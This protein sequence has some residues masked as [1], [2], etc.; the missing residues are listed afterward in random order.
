MTERET[1]SLEIAAAPELIGLV[2]RRVAEHARTLAFGEDD[3]DA[4]VLAVGEACS[5]AVLYG[6]VGVPTP[7]VRVTCALPTPGCLQ[8]DIQNQ[9]N[10]F[11]PNLA[12]LSSL[13]APAD[14]ATHGRGFALMRA[15]VDDVQVMSDG[16]NTTVRL[17]KLSSHA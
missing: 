11:H 3:V 8:I 1:L 15:L 16:Y 14:F 10:G 5:N 9:G 17:T 13:P 12:V 2:R 6:G 7:H 4:L